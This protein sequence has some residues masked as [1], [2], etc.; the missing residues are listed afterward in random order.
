M[1]LQADINW[2]KSELDRVSD[3]SFVQVLKSLLNHRNQR[4]TKD[5]WEDLPTEVQ[6]AVDQGLADVEAGRTHTYSEVR[7]G[8][9]DEFNL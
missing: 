3:P 7:Q 8:I 1:S 5:W 9:K 4:K 2:I 6:R